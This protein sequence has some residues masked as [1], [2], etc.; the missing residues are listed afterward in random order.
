MRAE[1]T[2]PAT[3]Q[4]KEILMSKK[5]TT[6]TILMIAAGLFNGAANAHPELQSAEPAA[7]AAMTTS[8][9]QIRITFNENVIPKFSGVELKDQ[10]GKMIATGNAATDPGNKMQLLVPVQEPL[11]PGDY[12]VEWHAVSD[13]THR[14]TGSYSFSVAR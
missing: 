4:S 11:P 10:T 1:M 3:P 7:G 5:T 8:P 2:I 13:D 6:A 14:V 12:K 9:T